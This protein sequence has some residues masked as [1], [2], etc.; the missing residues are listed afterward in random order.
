M[1]NSIQSYGAFVTLKEGVDGLVHISAIQEGGVGKVED[2]LKEGQ[3]VQVRIVSFDKSKRRIGLSM[4][5]WTEESA[6]AE[7][8]GKRQRRGGRDD[9]EDDSA[10]QLTVEELEA[11]SVTVEPTDMDVL[12]PF[13]A[14]FARADEKQTLKA[15]GKKFA[16]TL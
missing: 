14:A 5:P 15:S 4:K 16:F 7:K 12:S 13:D 9:F 10:F 1:G 11:L 6:A 3:E 8:S 2:V